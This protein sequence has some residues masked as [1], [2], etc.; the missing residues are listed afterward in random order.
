[1]VRAYHDAGIEVILDVVYN[2][3]AGGNE[4]G[5]TLSFKGLITS[6]ITA[7]CRISTGIT[8]TTPAPGTPLILPPARIA[9]GHGLPALLGRIDAD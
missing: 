2:H 6:V 1:M 5:P 8:S 3:T 4:L 9:D 7:P